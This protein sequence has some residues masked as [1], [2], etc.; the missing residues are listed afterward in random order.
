MQTPESTPE[1]GADYYKGMSDQYRIS[2]GLPFRSTV[3]LPGFLNVLGKLDSED[4][5]DVGCGEGFYTRIVAGQTSGRVVGID[6]S[7]G[8]VE[9]ARTQ[10]IDE[11]EVEYYVGDCSQPMS[12]PNHQQFDV[13]TTGFV[14]TYARS[15]SM[16]KSFL[17]SIYDLVKPG[18]RF[19]G[20]NINPFFTTDLYHH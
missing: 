13:V 3:E 8:M 20:I 5:A 6:I 12:F 10:K 19:V 2:K 16:L 4:V 14:L 18:G 17:T 11:R 15:A 1:H 9:L 7:E